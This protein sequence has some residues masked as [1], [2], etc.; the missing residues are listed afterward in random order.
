MMTKTEL[1]EEIRVRLVIVEAYGRPPVEGRRYFR[2][3]DPEAYDGRGFMQDTDDR[4]EAA[5]LTADD[6]H[7]LLHTVPK[8]RPRRPDGEPNKPMMG[9]HF[10]VEPVK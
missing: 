7:D 8:S 6:L 1:E 4:A 10:E 2:A 5:L 3:F 9:V